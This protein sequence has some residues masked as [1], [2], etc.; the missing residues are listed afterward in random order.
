MAK[1]ID[2]TL[3]FI[4]CILSL[5]GLINF[6]SVSIGES[7]KNAKFPLWY[8]FLFVIKVTFLGAVAFI[9]GFLLSKNFN[10]HKKIFFLGFYVL[11]LSL[12]LLLFFPWLTVE[13]ATSKRWLNLGFITIQPAELIKPFVILFFIYFLNNF[14]KNPI[15]H[16]LTIFILFLLVISVP[17]LLQPALS[18]LMIIIAPL[19]VIFFK[20]LSRWQETFYSFITLLLFIVLIISLSL[21]WSYRLERAL[22]FFSKGEVYEEKFF[23]VWQTMLAV[24]EGGFWGK[25][26]GLSEAK[27]NN[28]PQIMTDSI[29]AIYAAEF[30]FL[31]SLIL[32]ILFLLLIWRIISLGQNAGS[33]IKEYFSLGVASWLLLQFFLHISSNIG[34]FIPTGVILPFFSYGASGQIAIY[35]SLGIISGFRR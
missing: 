8:F 19:V 13:E 17:I 12:L 33:T 6:F 30:G 7:L 27:K 22:A 5:L 28:I 20:S 10:D 23:Q 9:V 16:R 24:S 3:L 4:V 11:Y 34:L 14:K 18:N 15:S 21:L 2:F 29:F 25:G 31:G 32:I 1:K 26:L 35:F